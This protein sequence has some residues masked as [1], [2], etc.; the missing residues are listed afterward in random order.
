MKYE[1]L[2]KSYWDKRMVNPKV[3]VFILASLDLY[4]EI[5]CAFDP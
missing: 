3:A 1:E 2:M 4:F 5:D